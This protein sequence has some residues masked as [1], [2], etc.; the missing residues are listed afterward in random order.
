MNLSV[1]CLFADSA[2]KRI[3]NSAITLRIYFSVNLVPNDEMSE[4]TKIV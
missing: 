2:E 3:L 4:D 1:L